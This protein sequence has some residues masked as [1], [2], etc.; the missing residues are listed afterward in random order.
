MTPKRFP[1]T[2]P[3]SRC[4]HTVGDNRRE[5]EDKLDGNARSK[6]ISIPPRDVWTR[7]RSLV[8]K[9]LPLRP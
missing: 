9:I 6:L 1:R 3:G 4:Q 5:M 7:L 8:E 2:P